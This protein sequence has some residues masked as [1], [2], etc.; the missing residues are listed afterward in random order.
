MDGLGDSRAKM[1][2]DCGFGTAASEASCGSEHF[3]GE[4]DE[5]FEDDELDDSLVRVG[6]LDRLRGRLRC[7]RAGG[8]GGGG[9]LAIAAFK[10]VPGAHAFA[11]PCGRV[12]GGGGSGGLLFLATA[13]GSVRP[14]PSGALAF[15]SAARDC[16]LEEGRLE[17]ELES[18]SRDSV[19]AP[20]P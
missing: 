8:G 17:L 10:V 18:D 20:L 2:R 9:G 1:S 3:L 5:G 7:C 19:V 14:A 6:V 16:E 15:A 12:G 11:S 13:A 4:A